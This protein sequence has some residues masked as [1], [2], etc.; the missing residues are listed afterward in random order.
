[1][2]ITKIGLRILM[3]IMI[4][5]GGVVTGRAGE[6][7]RPEA[8]TTERVSVA[9]DGTEGNAES[10]YSDISADGRYVTFESY[11]SNLVT[12]DTNNYCEYDGDDDYDE[13]CADVFIHDRQTG[14]TTRVSV[15]SG[16]TQGNEGSYDPTL[17]ADGRYVAFSSMAT[18][19]VAD[20]TNGK[21][22][23]FVHDRES[24][25]TTLVS[26]DNYG[27]QANGWSGWARISADGQSVAF[28]SSATNL[29]PGDV[30]YRDDI[31]VRDLVN[32]VTSMVSV[33]SSGSDGQDTSS[34]PSISDDGRYV[35][36]DSWSTNLVDGDTNEF[37]DIFVHDRESG[38]TTRVSVASDGTQGDADS[39]EPDISGDGQSVAFYSQATNLVIGDV[40]GFEDVF[41]HD[42]SSGETTLVSRA[43]D[44][45]PG[46]Y[47]S[48]STSISGDGRYVAFKSWADNLVVGDTNGYD[49]IFLHDRTSGETIQVS[50]ATDGTQSDDY[51]W[52]P[53]LSAGGLI[54]AF[55]SFATNLVAG[56]TNLCDND[57][58]GEYDDP[59]EDVFVHE[60]GVE[61][62]V[63]LVTL[64][65][66]VK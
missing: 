24:G 10:S 12:G 20:D 55:E 30:N 57:H 25:V 23:I 53:S 1:M 7:A 26:V 19:L 35:A 50:I 2:N 41:V 54:V 43:S 59:C 48:S 18:N 13:N 65:L 45:T 58:D 42:R 34:N 60:V 37:I 63:I 15:A 38:E 22:D 9:S 29:H 61:A 4:M 56:D 21:T 51:S 46:N 17:S 44:G 8:G 49:D 16:G 36:F 14:E 33:S 52:S 5:A 66:V 40:N 39:S 47:G 11:A 3:A 27:W 28:A 6:Q 32:E 62:A 31:F 64:P